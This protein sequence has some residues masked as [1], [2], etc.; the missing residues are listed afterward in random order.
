[1]KNGKLCGAFAESAEAVAVVGDDS[2]SK[3]VT[4]EAKISEI[5][6]PWM[7]LVW[8]WQ[9]IDVFDSWWINVAAKTVE[10]WPKFGPANYPGVQATANVPFDPKKEHT[11]KVVSKG[12]TFDIF[13][14][15]KEASS[16]TNGELVKKGGKVGVLVW[17]TSACFDDI[18]ITGPN[19]RGLAVDPA[20]KY[21]TT[22]GRIK[23]SY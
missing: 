5:N 2:W 19:V 13:F 22:W 17:Q 1:V 18:V 21:T 8:N 11:L 7:A 4:I 10:A 23:Q 15:G 3:E 6:G 12:G 16:Y 14:D 9:N 20:E